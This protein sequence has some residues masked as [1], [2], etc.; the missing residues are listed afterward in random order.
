MTHGRRIQEQPG[1]LMPERIRV[2]VES[3]SGCDAM[4]PVVHLDK[5]LT[6]ILV[7]KQI[8]SGS[9]WALYPVLEFTRLHFALDVEEASDYLA[10]LT[11]CARNETPA[12]QKGTLQ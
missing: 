12:R 6:D 3:V 10:V 8:T 7:P 9:G 2:I 5:K 4:Q 1:P 11:T